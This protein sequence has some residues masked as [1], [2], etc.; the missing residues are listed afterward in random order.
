M[1][2]LRTLD[3][4]RTRH[5]LKRFVE[6]PNRL[7]AD[8]PVFVP[9]LPSEARRLVDRELN[10]F[11]AYGEAEL[12]MVRDK[13]KVLGRIAAVDNPRHNAVHQ[14]RDGFFCQF[15]CVDDPSVAE[16]LFD[17][18]AQWLR[19]RGLETMVG[20]VNFTTH[21]EC[22]LL[23]EGFDSAPRVMM[24]Y[25]PAYYPALLETCGLRKAK[26]LW[27]WSHDLSPLDERLLRIAGFVQRRKRLSVRPLDLADF[28]AEA[29][30][31]RHV[32]ES[33]WRH[34]WGFTPATD[35]EFAVLA[36]RLRPMIDP[37]FVHLAEVAG[38]PVGVVLVVPDVN[39]A[40]AAMH[41]NTTRT[42]RLVDL[43]RMLLAPPTID[44]TRAML[45]GVVP[46]LRG[47][48]IETLLYVR[49]HEALKASAYQGGVELGWTLEDNTAVNRF[50]EA[51]G[52]TRAKT[53]RIYQRAL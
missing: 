29:Q 32:Y 25:N 6:A 44:R 40:V 30:R 37:R 43:A 42:G 4:V 52:C 1:S 35:E 36:R 45:F 20:P 39:Q 21:E 33:A 34:N 5:D 24:P 2:S 15:A 22:G 28:D 50:L 13:G 27:A 12:F 23:V 3:P 26:D 17:A 8:D 41:G 16:T 47:C 46:R 48:G 9:S 11:F 53:Y 14:A 38:E 51:G 18:A 10:P 19:G 49:V 7:H 31:I